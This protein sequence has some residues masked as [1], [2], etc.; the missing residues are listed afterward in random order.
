ME[1]KRIHT[2]RGENSVDILNKSSANLVG[3]LLYFD[4]SLCS[5]S[6]EEYR[7]IQNMKKLWNI[8]CEIN[9]ISLHLVLPLIDLAMR[10]GGQDYEVVHQHTKVRR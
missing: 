4:R 2:S 5:F 3:K 1:E 10:G 7:K 8:Q 9:P 6:N